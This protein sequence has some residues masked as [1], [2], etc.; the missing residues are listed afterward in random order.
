MKRRCLRWWF[1][2]LFGFAFTVGGMSSL[3]A[4]EG[5]S[6]EFV[7]EEITVTAQKRAENQQK[8]AI[9][10]DV[11]TGEDLLG[12]EK[13]NVDDI[14]RD[15]SNIII[16]K[17]DDGMRITLRGISDYLPLAGGVKASSPTVAVNIDGAYTNESSGGQNLFDLERVE[18]LAG[19][20][21]TLYGSNSPGGVVNVVTASPKTDRF[22]ATGSAEI[23]NYG[24]FDSSVVVNVPIIQDLLAMRLSAKYYERDSWIEGNPNYQENT[25]VRLKTK[26][27]P[28]DN[29]DATLTLS[30]AEAASGGRLNGNVKLFGFEDGFWANEE[31]DGVPTPVTNPWTSPD[32]ENAAAAGPMSKTAET[33][34]LQVEVNWD[35]A[36]GSIALVPFYNER[37]SNDFR[38]DVEVTLAGD[39]TIYYTEQYSENFNKQQGADMRISSPAD[40]PFKW[41]VGGTVFD[42]NQQN[43]TDDLLYDSNDRSQDFNQDNLAFYANVT[44]PITDQFRGTLG[45]RYSWDEV[46]NF[47]VGGKKGP[48][49]YLWGQEYEAPDYKVG[50]EYDLAEN[51]MAWASYATS[52]RVDPMAAEK[53]QGAEAETLDSYSVG[54]KNRFL[55]NKLQVNATAYYYDYQN[56]FFRGGYQC[57]FAR[58]AVIRESDYPHDGLPGTD[59]NYDGDYIDTN[60]AP[61]GGRGGGSGPPPGMSSDLVGMT[62]VDNYDKQFGAFESLGVDVSV[63]WVPTPKDRVNLQVSYMDSEWTDAVTDFYWSWLWPDQGLD[64]SG[65]PA[66]LSPEWTLH[67]SYEHRFDLGSIG[68][69]IPEVDV[70]YKSDYILSFNREYTPGAAAGG[71]SEFQGDYQYYNYPWN[72]QEAHYMLNASLV[73]NHS[74][75]IWSLRTYVK[76]IENLAVKNGL[77]ARADNFRMGISDPRTYGAVLSVKF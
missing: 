33:N 71:T 17:Y 6:D 12:T 21:S 27:E 19:P 77:M 14:L 59:F 74:S 49:G 25:N 47:E 37:K 73:F 40:F 2:V 75:G 1:A 53:D 61:P 32:W 66:M 65:S 38:N 3:H 41:I 52:Y 76:N 34:A 15:V 62:I 13:D 35:T 67:A 24:L 64:F 45:Y 30:W 31:T 50:V 43:N 57:R 42:A 26:I 10:M 39:E 36:I 70:Q 23:G 51:S 72:Y 55:D 48:D 69:L 46:T 29:F 5:D 16:G 58:G 4:Q 7:L 9:Q 63:D 22:S 11:I 20:Q 68:T 54:V 18:V 56:K 8:V 44:Y 60:I 28:S